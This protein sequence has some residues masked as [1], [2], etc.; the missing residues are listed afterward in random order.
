MSRT[1]PRKLYHKCTATLSL[2]VN[3]IVWLL[4]DF[5]PWG[6]WPLG[7]ITTTHPGKDG[8]TRVCTVKTAF[9]T[10]ERLAVSLSTVFA[11]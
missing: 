3:D 7:K 11:P 2:K 4:Q 9:G 8:F 10:F 6:I 1:E 5:T